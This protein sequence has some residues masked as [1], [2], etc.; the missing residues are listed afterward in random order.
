MV[1]DRENYKIFKVDIA[2]ANIVQNLSGGCDVHDLAIEYS[3]TE[4]DILNF[5]KKIHKSFQKSEKIDDDVI[6]SNIVDYQTK[7]VSLSAPIVV[8]WDF[9]KKCC[10][11]IQNQLLSRTRFHP[12]R[13]QGHHRYTDPHE[14]CR[15]TPEPAK[16]RRNRPC[17]GGAYRPR[18]GIDP[19]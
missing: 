12:R 6:S 1:Y 18:T 8:F 19:S 14:L 2:T 3:C 13:Q 17:T 7:D 9:T 11:E 5:V 10:L 4:T 16:V 15:S